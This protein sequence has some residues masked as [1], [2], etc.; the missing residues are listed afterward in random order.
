M[1]DISHINFTRWFQK[2]LNWMIPSPPSLTSL[3][4]LFLNV[5]EYTS[6]IHVYQW[7]TSLM[8]NASCTVLCTPFTSCVKVHS[9]ETLIKIRCLI[10]GEIYRKAWFKLSF[11]HIYNTLVAFRITSIYSCSL[12]LPNSSF[13]QNSVHHLDSTKTWNSSNFPSSWM[14]CLLEDLWDINF[15]SIDLSNHGT[16]LIKAIA[17]HIW[18]L[19]WQWSF[20]LQCHLSQ[21]M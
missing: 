15:E 1:I 18:N 21:V 14:V 17:D 4:Q 3:G 20:S 16:A 13:Q 5:Q 11:P 12:A 8:I 9:V 6:V 10:F 2:L 19:P 7:K